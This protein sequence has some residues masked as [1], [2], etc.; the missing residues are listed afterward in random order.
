MLENFRK[1]T[2]VKLLPSSNKHSFFLRGSSEKGVLLVHGLTGSPV[3]M[4]YIGKQLHKRGFTV[5]APTLAGHCRDEAALLATTYQDW[6]DS[7]RE[8]LHYLKTQVRQVS[9]AGICVG[10]ALALYLS[11][12]EKGLID[13]V[14]IYAPALDYDGWNQPWWGRLARVFK[15]VLIRIPRVRKAH[16]EE[17]HPFGIKNDRMRKIL[18]NSPESMGGMLS[19]FPALSLYENYLLNDALKSA[20]PSIKTPTLLIHSK[21]DD[22]CHPRNSWQIRKR[23]GG[24]CEMILLENSYHMIH[25]D[26]ERQKVADLTAEFFGVPI[27]APNS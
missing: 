13:S 14:A 6:L 9:T 12:Q 17:T 18:L 8:A 22:V 21:D 19:H 15:D 24:R 16:I 25:V 4:K 7:L 23:H 27:R 20:L 5:Y 3:E 2:V 26:Q 1:T 10:G 11:Y